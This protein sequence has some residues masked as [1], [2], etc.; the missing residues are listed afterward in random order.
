MAGGDERFEDTDNEEGSVMSRPLRLSRRYFLQA[1]VSLVG[2]ALGGAF[3]VRHWGG[4]LK[5][6]LEWALI[7]P[8]L[9]DAFQGPLPEGVVSALVAATQGLV[10][11]GIETTHYA[12]FFRWRAESLRGYRALYERFVVALDREAREAGDTDFAGCG[13]A[14]RRAILRQ[15]DVTGTPDRLSRIHALVFRRDS[16]RFEKYIVR[17]VLALFSQTD[18]WVLLGYELW[19]GTP[20]GLELY[21]KAPSRG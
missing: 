16:L 3:A 5:S 9:G 21:T 7:D 19:P 18:G 2:L 15:I 1:V 10:D 6:R 13:M 20:R 4:T 17:E 14:R 11:T 8:T 12:T